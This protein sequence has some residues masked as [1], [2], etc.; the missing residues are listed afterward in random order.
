MPL[1]F[2]GTPEGKGFEQSNPT[3][4]WTVGHRRLDGDASLR[5]A[6]GKSAASPFRCPPKADT[7]WGVCFLHHERNA[8]HVLKMLNIYKT[9]TIFL[10]TF[11]AK[12]CKIT[13]SIVE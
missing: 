3:V 8:N 1:L 2:F 9:G 10:L 11:C 5:F 7:H 12:D 4:R 6:C 13:A